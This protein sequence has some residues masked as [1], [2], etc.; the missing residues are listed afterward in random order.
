MTMDAKRI[1]IA[2]QSDVWAVTFAD[3]SQ[4]V[5]GYAN[6]EIRRWKIEDGQQQGPTMQASHDGVDSVVVSQDG[7]R[8]VSG[9]R[10]RKAIVW[11]ATTHAKVRE[12][13]H[14][15]WVHEVDV[16]SDCTK[17]ASADWYIVE[18]FNMTSGIRP[19]PTLPHPHVAGVKFS[20]DGSQFA[21]ASES[22]GFRVYN[23]YNGDILFD[24]GQKGA[25]GSWS[26]SALAWSSDGQQLFVANKG[27]IIC[28][29]LS[30]SFFSE[31]SIHENRS[32]IS[33]II[34]YTAEIKRVALSPS[35]VYLACGNG[36][37]ITIHNLRDVLP[38]EYFDHGRSALIR[39]QLHASQLPLVRVSYE[40]LK[41]WTADDQ[42]NTERLLSEELTSASIPRHYLLANRALVR[43]R[44]KHLAP[45]IEDAKDSLRVQPSPIGH[46]AMAVALLG[47]GDREG[48][49]WIFDFASHDCNLHDNRFLLL[50]K[51]I[52]VFECGNQEEGIMRVEYLATR[53]NNDNDDDA[54]Y[55]HTQVL[56]VMY[57]KKGN[58]GRAIP[59]IERAKNL[60]SKDKQCPPLVT[61]SLIFGWSFSG[62]DIVAQQRLCETLYAEGRTTEA[63]EI[64]LNMIRTS[65]VDVQASKATADWVADFAKKC[66]AA[67]EHIGDEAFG[68]AKHD[69]TITQYSAMLPPSPAGLFI[70]RSRARAAKRLWEDALQDANEAVK[71]DPSSPWG[72]EAKREA[73]HGAKRYDEAIDAFKSML[74]V[75]EQSHDPAIRQ[76][77]KDFISPSET[78]AAVNAVIGGI[79][80]NTPLV[81][82]DVHTGCLCDVPERMRIFK[83]GPTFKEFVSSMTKEV[84]NEQILRMVAGFFGYIMFSHA[85][86]G[87]E[88]SF[89]DVNKVE[90]KSVWDLPDTPLNNKLRNF[91]KETRRLGYNWAWSDTCCIDKTT[92]PV[93]NQSLTSMYKWYANS[94]ATLVFLAGVTHPS[95]PGD[96]ARSLWMTRA[97][98]LQEL[99][100]PT[101][102]LFYDSEW[103]LYL[104]D[105]SA[106]H[107]ESEI[108]QELADAIGVP[109]GTIVTFSPDDLGVREKLRLASSR[110]AT[111]EEDVAYSLIGIFKSDIKP[112]YGEGIDALGHLLEEIVARSG[113]VTVLEWSGKSSSYNSCLPTSLSVYSQIPHSP[114]SL[115]GEEMERRIKELGDKLPRQQARTIFNRINR[116]SPARFATRRLH[117]PCIVFSV[118]SLE[119]LHP[120]S[121]RRLFS[122]EKLYR[123]R[124]SGLGQ[125][126]FTTAD[127]LSL[128]GPQQLVFAHPWIHYIRGP[129]GGITW[130]DDAE[131]DT[132]SDS[133]EVAPL[134]AAPAL[135]IDN[136]TRALEMIARLG[137]PFSAFLLLKQPNGEY[138]RVAAENEIVVPGLGTNITSK[139]IRAKVLEIL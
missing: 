125:V 41:S 66:A 75:I 40:T 133:A 15:G 63:V 29:D 94:A 5:G 130:E 117:L 4:V 67:L 98:T 49:L 122:D 32:P 27:K 69:D 56:G 2:S 31:W 85:W 104:G 54:T 42:M 106:N 80:K 132:D 37:N 121:S 39:Q 100:S 87:S 64:L 79:L 120:I 115:E 45:A 73:L 30:K 123:A 124:V 135:Q 62:L 118:R 48:A 22:Y 18:I 35:G 82:I 3:E 84:D 139:N 19:L 88:P 105:T 107:K 119:M 9:D 16:S 92:G 24:S 7:R 114:P 97:W 8:I 26:R 136:Y 23:T 17:I 10:G 111:V 90:S 131:S 50:L 44:L 76:L 137:Q 1:E 112:Y 20:P 99:L 138:K 74:Q 102:I 71:A 89:Q 116:L 43:A 28:F 103:K 126:E 108:M 14:R 95:K 77:R 65:D 51:S 110:S 59:L 93:L 12:L 52:L 81:V 34:S 11:N 72:Y 128:N 83:A 53:A 78:I 58:Y 21:S 127:R 109:R 25:T 47:Q 57:L 38:S 13:E 61:I 6:G 55:L 96:L 36:K 129:S 101:V 70:K 60:A 134:P 91:C 33:G 113:E 46:I 86:Q 68:S